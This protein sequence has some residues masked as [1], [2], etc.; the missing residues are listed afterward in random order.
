MGG[1]QRD[2]ESDSEGEATCSEQQQ[3]LALA[4]AEQ[5]GELVVTS[6]LAIASADSHCIAERPASAHA[7][8]T[9]LRLRW[10]AFRSSVAVRPELIIPKIASECAQLLQQYNGDIHRVAVDTGVW[11][12]FMQPDRIAEYFGRGSGYP[13]LWQLLQFAQTGVPANIAGES[14]LRA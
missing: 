14:C 4:H 1:L 11:E 9:E 8:I 3:A 13:R 10:R 5:E 2:E 6:D 12:H 7:A